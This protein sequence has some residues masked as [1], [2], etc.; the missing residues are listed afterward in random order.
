MRRPLVG[1]SLALALFTLA[2][3]PA[4]ACGWSCCGCNTYGY[5]AAPAYSYYA[6]VYSYYRAPIYSYYAAP[7]YS[8][9]APRVYSYYPARRLRLQLLPILWPGLWRLLWLWLRGLAALVDGAAALL[10]RRTTQA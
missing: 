8:Y 6:P 1:V 2:S 7:V 9:Y 3:A 10:A 4:S 5:Y